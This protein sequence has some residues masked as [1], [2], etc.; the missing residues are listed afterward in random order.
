MALE[1]EKA[2]NQ[3]QIEMFKAEQQAQLKQQRSCKRQP[4]PQEAAMQQEAA[5][6][7]PAPEP[8]KRLDQV[9][10]TLAQHHGMLQ[11]LSKPRRRSFIAIRAPAR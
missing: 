9:L 4:M 7:P 1:R 10:Q 11:S 6:R 2:Q 3:I 8:D 5:M